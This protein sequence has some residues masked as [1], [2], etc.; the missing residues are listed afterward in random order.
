MLNSGLPQKVGCARHWSNTLCLHQGAVCQ[1]LQYTQAGGSCLL[2][3]RAVVDSTTT[4]H[5]WLTMAAAEPITQTLDTV[6]IGAVA[7]TVPHGVV[8]ARVAGSER[9][10]G[11]GL[12]GVITA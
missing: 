8:A 11:T 1:L 5:C 12:H 7:P 3:Q 9:R 6:A 10:H 4:A 2:V